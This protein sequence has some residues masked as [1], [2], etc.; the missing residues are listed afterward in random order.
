MKSKF[1]KTL[2][3]FGG[4]LFYFYEGWKSGLLSPYLKKFFALTKHSLSQL[5]QALIE[6][7]LNAKNTEEESIQKL[8]RSVSGL[9]S[10]LPT[11]SRFNYSILIYV[12]QPNPSFFSQSLRSVLQQSTV[13][14]VLI[15]YSGFPSTETTEIVQKLKKTSINS[16][17]EFIFNSDAEEIFIL[18]EL[19]HKSGSNFLFIM[20]QEDWIR[21]DL[22][23][24]Y[25]Q[26]LRLL[27]NPEMTVLY[28]DENKI[29]AKNHF[30]PLSDCRKPGQLHF[31]FFFEFFSEKGLLIPK[32]LW[33]LINGLK[34][35][36][37]GAEYEDL[38][39]RLEAAGAQ[40]QH[41]PLSLYSVREGSKQKLMNRSVDAFIRSLKDYS[42]LKKLNWSISTNEYA[43]DQVKVIP[44]INKDHLIQVVIPFKDQKELTIKCVHS[45]LKQRN[46]HFKITAI[47]NGS[48]DES[49]ANE[50]RDLGCE[51][52]LIRE[53]FNYSRLNNLAIHHTK[54]AKTCDL[55]LF[56]NNDIELES[57]AI[58]EMQRWIDQPSIGM[59]GCRLHYPNHS[60]QHCGI[61]LKYHSTTK[62]IWEH[63][64]KLRL[65]ETSDL[66]KKL[67]V[68]DAVTAACVLVKKQNFLEVGGFDEIWYPIGYSDTHLAMKLAKKQ[69]WS[70]YTPYAKGMHYESISRKQ[71]IEDFESSWWLHHLV[72]KYSQ[73]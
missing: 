12:N 33:N 5:N 71:S 69:L 4:I 22:F 59:V 72:A 19:A 66:A 49:I 29:N 45:I 25:E 61:D 2:D 48:Q 52:L 28:C 57:D 64:E 44:E 23:F 24:R 70:F 21:P 34:P 38:L 17:Q 10:L 8:Q 9:Q 16:I 15:G 31:P 43:K 68:T 32:H 41:I 11:D 18:N 67:R 47:D 20:G 13:A 46:V 1:R 26:I 50:L 55:I 58:Y 7:N 54:I 73:K 60:L 65:F 36:R 27:P 56:V 30:I 62:M 51:V 39:L 6:H 40:F 14:D 42:Q 35:N 3:L 37:V 53:P 63:T